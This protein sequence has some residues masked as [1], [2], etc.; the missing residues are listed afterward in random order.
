MEMLN[1]VL[2]RLEASDSAEVMK[3]SELAKVATTFMNFNK[4]VITYFLFRGAC[5]EVVWSSTA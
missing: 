4:F 5:S 2:K 3:I 1:S